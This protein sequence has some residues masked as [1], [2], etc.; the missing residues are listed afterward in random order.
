VGALSLGTIQVKPH[1]IPDG[2]N[3][4]IITWLDCRDGRDDIYA[5][6][7]GADGSVKWQA[8][9]IMIREGPVETGSTY[10]VPQIAGDSVGGAIITWQEGKE[11]PTFWDIFGQ[12]VDAGGNIL[13][14]DSAVSVCRATGGQYGPRIISNGENGVIIS[15]R[16][17]R[18]GTD[19]K[20]YAMR[21][22]ANGE[23]VATLLQ[24]WAA[25]IEEGRIRI[26]WSLSEID[27]DVRFLVLRSDAP[28]GSYEELTLAEVERQGLSFSC[29]DGTCEA[30][31][32]YRYRVDMEVDGSRE[33]LFETEVVA[34]PRM[35]LAL[36]QNYP[37]PFNP[38]TM[39]EYRLPEKT[40][41]RLEIYDTAGR[42]VACIAEGEQGAG[43]HS[44]MWD[45]KDAKGRAVSSGVYFYCLTAGKRVV[46]KKMVL[47][48]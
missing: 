31:L 10:G 23:T 3:G 13:W 47:L 25:S 18:E 30:G 6:R 28:N 45:G 11:S 21:V 20:V 33:M 27:A 15:W 37:N 24:S 14:A 36:L 41:L 48:K 34:L 16:D 26:E 38:S 39:I 17:M 42:R 32:S 12:R 5:Q 46:T 44:V 9:G 8:D 35:E 2:S 22:T 19:G 29:T 7:V 4:A 1:L 43:P 40:R